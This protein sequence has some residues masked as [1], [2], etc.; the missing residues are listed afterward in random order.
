MVGLLRMHLTY[1]IFAL[2]KKYC[3]YSNNKLTIRSDVVRK[4]SKVTREKRFSPYPARK[5]HFRSRLKNANVVF[6]AR[7]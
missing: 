1:E 5:Y 7:V 6:S 2:K 4:I 3:A